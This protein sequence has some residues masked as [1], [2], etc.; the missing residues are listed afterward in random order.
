MFTG[1]DILNFFLQAHRRIWPTS[2][3]FTKAKLNTIQVRFIAQ[4]VLVL[5][6]NRY[7]TP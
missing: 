7:A 6:L 1:Q 5:A 4:K 2:L 3:P